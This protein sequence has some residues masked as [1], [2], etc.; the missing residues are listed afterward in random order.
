MSEPLPQCRGC[1]WNLLGLHACAAH[2]CRGVSTCSR[3][4]LTNEGLELMGSS[5]EGVFLYTLR[6]CWQI[7]APVA[8]VPTCIT[9]PCINFSSFWSLP[10]LLH[11]SYALNLLPYKPPQTNPCLR[12]RVQGKLNLAE[13]PSACDETLCRFW[14]LCLL[15]EWV[16]PL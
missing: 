9:H 8:T 12:F 10:S 11:K 1:S 3:K 4:P 6:K 15:H 2:K 13:K 16:G 14:F 7:G 5:G